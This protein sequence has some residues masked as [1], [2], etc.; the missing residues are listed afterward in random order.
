MNN[1]KHFF[2]AKLS[3]NKLVGGILVVAGLA[4][5]FF[6]ISKALKLKIPFDRGNNIG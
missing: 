1:L 6:L 3:K 5:L 4:I 2:N